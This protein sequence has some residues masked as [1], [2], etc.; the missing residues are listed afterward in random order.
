MFRLVTPKEKKLIN[1]ALLEVCGTTIGELWPNASAIVV[2]RKQNHVFI[3]GP[4]VLDLLEAISK[5]KHQFRDLSLEFACKEVGILTRNGI[6]IGLEILYELAP[7]ISD[8]LTVNEA[9]E[10]SF[11][12][13]NGIELKNVLSFPKNLAKD[14]RAIVFSQRDHPLGLVQIKS[15]PED[16]DTTKPFAINLID[17][18]YYLRSGG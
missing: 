2:H 16:E 1:D 9:G 13:G 10:E 12:F 8:R 11:L 4:Q 14:Q 3:I 5:N 18:G 17:Y 7:Y 15:L 6:R